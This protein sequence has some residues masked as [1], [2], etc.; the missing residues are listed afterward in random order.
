MLTQD[1]AV[2]NAVDIEAMARGNAPLDLVLPHTSILGSQWIFQH[3][4]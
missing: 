1:H 3:R 2:V 4:L